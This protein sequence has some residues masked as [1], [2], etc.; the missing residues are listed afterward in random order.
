MYDRVQSPKL[1]QVILEN[2]SYLQ[3]FVITAIEVYPNVHYFLVKQSSFIVASISI[4]FVD[5]TSSSEKNQDL[6][7]SHASHF[8]WFCFCFSYLYVLVGKLMFVDYQS[9]DKIR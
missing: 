2:R 5:K 6:L 8:L 7:S 4:I 3:C 9:T 1:R